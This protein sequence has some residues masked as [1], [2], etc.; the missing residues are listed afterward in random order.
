[1]A[2]FSNV[3]PHPKNTQKRSR[4]RVK[5]LSAGLQQEKLR[6]ADNYRGKNSQISRDYM[7]HASMFLECF[8]SKPMCIRSVDRCLSAG[9]TS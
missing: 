3:R 9:Y 2:A 8:P 6:T 1:M 7:N 4:K 5:T